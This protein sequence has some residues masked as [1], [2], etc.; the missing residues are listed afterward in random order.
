[1]ARVSLKSNVAWLS[2][3]VIAV[4]AGVQLAGP[5][6]DATASIKQELLSA[7]MAPYAAFHEHDASAFCAD[8]TKA[9]VAH[10]L[11]DAQA[12]NCIGS[13]MSAFTNRPELQ[14]LPPL[15]R[16]RWF[17]V[18][19][20]VVRGA[21]AGVEVIYHSAPLAHLALR[22]E[23]ISGRWRVATRP[24]LGLAVGCLRRLPCTKDT[25]TLVFAIGFPG[26]GGPTA[27]R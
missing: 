3:V 18:S 6:P 2:V 23:R 21:I 16:T 25:R 26:I 1:M 9:A 8:F 7:V 14:A 22:L 19:R 4:I 17:G 24:L 13:L 11:L 15:N 20:Y 10:V 5:R 12:G 27:G